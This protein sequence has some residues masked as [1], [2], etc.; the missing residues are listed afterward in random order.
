M[1]HVFI[2]TGLVEAE[3]EY[4]SFFILILLNYVVGGF[5]ALVFF[6]NPRLANLIPNLL[7]ALAGLAGIWFS[8]NYLLFG[9]SRLELFTYITNIPYVTINAVM[10]RLSAYFVLALSLLGFCV[11]LYSI[12][13]LTHYYGQR[14]VWLFNLLYNLFILSMLLVLTS[15]NLIFFLMA[16]ELMSLFSYF[17]VIF[18]TEHPESQKA[19]LLYLIMTHIG[20]AFLFI[21]FILICQ[22][23]HTFGIVKT[24]VDMPV[25]VKNITFIF[26]LIGFGMKAGVIPLH[27]WLP[28]AHPAA[29]SNVSALMSGIMIKTALYGLLRFMLTSLGPLQEWWGMLILVL[30]LISTVLGVAYALMEHNIKRLLAYHSIE[31]I[32][33]ILTGIGIVFL[34]QARGNHNLAALALVAA[35]FHIL[36][37]TLFKGALFLGA[38]S[39]QFAT[40]TKDL[41]ELGGL[42]KKMPL[43][44]LF[45]LVASLSISALPPFNGF[46]S[47]WLTYQA[48]FMNLGT[49]G[50]AMKL[51]S[52]FAVAGLAMAG[53][54]A[55]YC[56]VKLNG[57]AFLGLPRSRHA[58]GAKEVPWTMVLG[59]GLLSLLCLVLGVFPVLVTRLLDLVNTDLLGVSLDGTLRSG[60]F[61]VIYPM[62]SWSSDLNT[63]S[64]LLLF[65]TGLVIFGGTLIV[66]RL[67]GGRREERRYGTWDCGFIGLTP[68]MQYTATGF[69]KPLRIVFRLLYQPTRE[70]QVEEGSSPYFHKSMRYIVKTEPV[71]ENYLYRPVTNYFRNLAKRARFLVQTGSI[72]TYLIYMF[73]TILALL[74]Y[75]SLS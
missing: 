24:A 32:G 33:I 10:D 44:G 29:P 56:F 36:N 75:Y 6:K 60:L 45:F 31:N 2:F 18:E 57:I 49:G 53:A 11:S 19:G 22:Y 5:S 28:Y 34:S 41:E 54:L 35:L 62:D 40:H 50:A 65:I 25:S 26:L 15:G 61:L 42:L 16:W 64:P 72:H 71:F 70:L 1:V 74:V 66:I 4:S 59:S 48:L 3:M 14:K 68:R 27:I 47:E 43:T 67:V 51:I 21:A 58:A 8:V 7:A 37:H 13:Y 73:V 39:L 30:G 9:P 69:S 12:G 23:T 46:V 38:G 52:I 17:L 63:I 55:A 20:T